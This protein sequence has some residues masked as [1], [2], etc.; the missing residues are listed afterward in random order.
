MFAD[1]LTYNLVILF[2]NNLFSFFPGKPVRISILDKVGGA[3][4]FGQEGRAGNRVAARNGNTFPTTFNFG[5]L[6]IKCPEQGCSN[7][8]VGE[9]ARTQAEKINGFT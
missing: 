7:T 5:P 2:T 6:L 9:K 8:F 3:S 1:R 4:L